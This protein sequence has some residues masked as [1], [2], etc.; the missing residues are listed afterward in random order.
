MYA[1]ALIYLFGT[2]IALGSF[3]GLLP[4]AATMP[5]LIWRL[6]D[7]E[8]FLAKN[9]PGYADYQRTV[10]SRLIPHIF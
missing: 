4:L 9:L 6:Y 10:R 3:W 7:E 5:F 1:S 8:G 2:P